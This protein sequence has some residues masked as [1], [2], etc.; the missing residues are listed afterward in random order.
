VHTNVLQL[1]ADQPPHNRTIH[2][3]YAG[4]ALRRHL[5]NLQ[6]VIQIATQ[7]SDVLGPVKLFEIF[8]SFKTF[9]GFYYSLGSIVNLPA[10]SV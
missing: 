9:E 1:E 6:V 5:P 7:Y 10:L 2:G 8:Q 3:M 4:D